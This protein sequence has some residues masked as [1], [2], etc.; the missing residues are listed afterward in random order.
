MKKIRAK[1]SEKGLQK[2]QLFFD[3]SI[4]TLLQELF[5]NSRRANATKVSISVEEIKT[6]SNAKTLSGTKKGKNPN[7]PNPPNPLKASSLITIEDNGNGISNPEILLHLWDSDWDQ[8]TQKLESPAGLGFFSLCHL[9]N[10]VQVESK[11]WKVKLSPETFSGQE[12]AIVE[13]NDQEEM[14]RQGTKLVFEVNNSPDQCKTIIE[15]TLKY[16]PIP[17]TLNGEKTEQEDFLDNCLHIYKCPGGRIGIREL[18]FNSGYKHNINFHG[19]TLSSNARSIGENSKVLMPRDLGY[20]VLIDVQDNKI[21]DL[22]LPA[23]NAIVENEK[24]ESLAIHCRKALYEY[25]ALSKKEHQIPYQYYQEAL[26][27]GVNLQEATPTLG[28]AYPKALFNNYEGWEGLTAE[29]YLDS[30]KGM[31]RPS[32]G[33]V[34]S[35]SILCGKLSSSDIAALHISGK[36]IPLMFEPNE[37]LRGYSWYPK[38]EALELTQVL[39]MGN[40]KSISLPTEGF[41]GPQQ[42]LWDKMKR[43]EKNTHPKNVTLELELKVQNSKGKYDIE[44]HKIPSPIAINTDFNGDEGLDIGWIPSQNPKTNPKE[45]V[46]VELLMSLFFNPCDDYE[47]DSIESQEEFFRKEADSYLAWTFQEQEEA[48]IYDAH[49][50]LNSWDVRNALQ[51]LD[52]STIILE[53]KDG[54]PTIKKIKKVGKSKPNPS[55]EDQTL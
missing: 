21:L 46:D 9:E 32:K 28:Y 41:T 15:E 24:L 37:S 54:R 12:D 45:I 55:V 34:N 5:Q 6:T 8:T 26:K 53:M 35:E 10:G 22:V 14:E 47:G 40:K 2:V 3:N 23:R 33:V 7:P 13:I 44:T 49:K 29:N 4:R 50:A 18:N 11:N 20:E 42:K 43:S 31:T 16:Y 17:T 1:M 39:D 51:K 19:L 52:A 30:G 27:M 38:N 48:I 25:L 36:A